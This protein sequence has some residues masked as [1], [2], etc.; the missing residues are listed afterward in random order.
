MACEKPVI[1]SDAGGTRELVVNNES[2]F[3]ITDET[4]EEIAA[5]ISELLDN[6]ERRNTIGR[7]AR[8]RIE[9]NFSIERMGA[10]FSRMYL[11]IVG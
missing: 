10:E 1:A 6:K 5:L 11:E 3:L 4:T 2:G 9:R 7:N 8:L